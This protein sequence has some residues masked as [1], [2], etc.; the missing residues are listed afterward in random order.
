[1]AAAVMVSGQG[2]AFLSKLHAYYTLFFSCHTTVALYVVHYRFLLFNKS[3]FH[4]NFLRIYSS[5]P[6]FN[7]RSLAKLAVLLVA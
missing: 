3:Q 1:M 4:V 7:A 6:I 2:T 5:W